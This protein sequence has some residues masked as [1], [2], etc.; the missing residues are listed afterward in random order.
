M[1]CSSVTNAGS[2]TV[3]RRSPLVRPP[4][5]ARRKRSA[6]SG[7]KRRIARPAESSVTSVARHGSPGPRAQ[8]SAC[9]AAGTS[10]VTVTLSPR[11]TAAR[12]TDSRT[13][14][15]ASAS[16]RSGCQ[17]AAARPAPGAA[18]RNSAAPP[19]AVATPNR[20]PRRVP[21]PSTRATRGAACSTTRVAR[22]SARV[23]RSA[24][25][26]PGG[27]G[28]SKP[29]TLPARV[30]TVVST[31]RPSACG[32]A[33]SRTRRANPTAT[34]RTAAIAS[35][36]PTTPATWGARR[37]P[38]AAMAKPS[39]A[40]ASRTAPARARACGRPSRR[41]RAAVPVTGSSSR[42]R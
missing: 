41:S 38:N 13:G 19:A 16:V 30:P 34:T 6:T 36:A 28:A 27:V 33:S 25:T 20:N 21:R 9:E 11:R 26:P 7:P 5:D 4:L 42:R 37:S 15:L 23:K 10:M 1:S 17:K 12:S 29:T 3:T 8:S 22:T 32:A 31:R 35:H 24:L 40:P 2:A 18:A 14:A 39:P